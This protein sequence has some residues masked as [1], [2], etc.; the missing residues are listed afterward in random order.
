MP[1]IEPPAMR[2]ELNS[3]PELISDSSATPVL[4]S[5]NQRTRPPT[6]MG[7]VVAIGR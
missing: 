7:A 2:P 3:V 6:K 4:R 1:A 5:T